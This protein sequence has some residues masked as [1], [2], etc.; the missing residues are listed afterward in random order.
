VLLAS[1]GL[2]IWVAAMALSGCAAIAGFPSD[3][4]NTSAVLTALT[5]YFD[6]SKEAAYSALTTPASRR[7]MRD[8]IVL[9]RI[10]AFDI[11]FA[12][13]EKTLWGTGNGVTLGGDLAALSLTGLA[14]TVGSTAAKTAYAAASTGVIGANA[15]ISRDL[16]FQRTLPALLAQMEANRAKARLKLMSGLK[17]TDDVYPLALADLDL[18]DL[19]T[20]GSMPAAVSNI[21]QQ[22]T[23]DKQKSQTTID[24]LRTGAVSTSATTIRLRNWASPNG[25]P[26]A[27]R[28]LQLQNWMSADMDTDLHSL[29]P[30]VLIDLNTPQMEGDRARAISAIPVP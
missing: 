10:R 7:A 24:A 30:E 14:T 25:Q 4:E 2:F 22:A 6:P 13:Y 17:S 11:E 16:Y 5:P 1:A 26:N 27:P 15:A 18:A 29:P 20:A 21:T 9:N 28:F 3:P 8:E 12:R 23:N 19:K